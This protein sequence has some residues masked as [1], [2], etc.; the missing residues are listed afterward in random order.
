[1]LNPSTGF[2]LTRLLGL[3]LACALVVGCTGGSKQGHAAKEQ[4]AENNHILKVVSLWQDYKTAIGHAPANADELK[5]WAKQQ[6]QAKLTT[7]GIDD[8]DKA[9]VS[10]RDNQPYG[11][12][13]TGTQMGGMTKVLVYEKTGVN[14]KR[15]T[16]SSMGTAA[17][18]DDQEFK[19][20]V[21]EQ[22]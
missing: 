17:E 11:L 4:P 18:V 10:P 15:L 6:D 14:G 19:R 9:F 16:A 1:M 12:V 21:P 3:L 7:H 13:Q 20:W 22:K 8:L 2:K 5:T